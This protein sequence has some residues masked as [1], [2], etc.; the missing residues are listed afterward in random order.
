MQGTG[1]RRDSSAECTARA[2]K[3]RGVHRMGNLMETPLS[4]L[5]QTSSTSRSRTH[6]TNGLVPSPLRPHVP[7][8]ASSM[9]K[10][11]SSLAKAP[12]FQKR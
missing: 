9:T 12:N 3:S 4:P 11:T 7:M 5:H 8:L 10:P 1:R 6:N 2:V